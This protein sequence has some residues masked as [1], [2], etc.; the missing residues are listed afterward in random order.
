MTRRDVRQHLYD[1]VDAC[2]AVAE[3]AEGKTFAD[4]QADRLLR[5]GIERQLTI[6]AEALNRGLK[7]DPS[8][9][10]RISGTLDIIAFRNVVVHEYDVVSDE[11]VARDSPARFL[12]R[13]R[14]SSSAGAASARTMS[15]TACASAK[16]RM[17]SMQPAKA[18]PESRTLESIPTPCAVNSCL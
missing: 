7:V 16:A 14:Y 17:T 3:F 4:C 2:R 10:E 6:A 5:S 13:A 11:V 8:L 15:N 9:A 18:G 1:I 12:R